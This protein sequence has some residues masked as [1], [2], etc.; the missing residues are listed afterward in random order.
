MLQVQYN[1]SQYHTNISTPLSGWLHVL[2]HPLTE[3]V[4]VSSHSSLVQF[5]SFDQVIWFVKGQYRIIVGQ[6]YYVSTFHSAYL[7]K[8]DCAREPSGPNN[9][10]HQIKY[11]YK[12]HVPSCLRCCNP[13]FPLLFLLPLPTGNDPNFD[14]FT[15]I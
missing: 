10:A 8:V 3:T 7:C 4:P 14:Q 9:M 2:N 5:K 15:M 6:I 11:K 1:G 12:A 13:V